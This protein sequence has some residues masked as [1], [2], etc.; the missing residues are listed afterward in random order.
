MILLNKIIKN[1]IYFQLE[2]L[3][4]NVNTFG[5]IFM[6]HYLSKSFYAVE[7]QSPHPTLVG[8]YAEDFLIFNSNLISFKRILSKT[9]F[10]RSQLHIRIAME[11]RNSR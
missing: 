3:Q 7:F 10:E 8:V 6:P 11:I 4:I 2:P 9:Y 5:M 1:E